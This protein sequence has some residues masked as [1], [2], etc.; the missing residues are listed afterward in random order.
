[1]KFRELEKQSNSKLYKVVDLYQVVQKSELPYSKAYDSKRD[2]FNHQRSLIKEE[3]LS[4]I[5]APKL[6]D[7]SYRPRLVDKPDMNEPISEQQR[8]A[9]DWRRMVEDERLKNKTFSQARQEDISAADIEQIASSLTAVTKPGDD[10]LA[11]A[12][13]KQAMLDTKAQAITTLA[14]TEIA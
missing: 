11:N 7:F 1:M 12:K 8:L 10:A 9:N 5:T 13:I 2:L 14:G 3:T 6:T 4:K